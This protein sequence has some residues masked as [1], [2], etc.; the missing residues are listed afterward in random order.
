MGDAPISPWVDFVAGTAGV[1]VRL[2]CP[3]SS[4]GGEYRT[5]W[6]TFGRIVKEEKVTGLYKGVMSPMLGVAAVNASVFGTY[7]LFMRMLSPE[8][9][10]TPTLGQI[11]VAGSGSGVATSIL[12]TPLE[13]LKI[14]Q[15]ISSS[16]PPSLMHLIRTLPTTSLYRG[17]TPTILRDLAYGPY[18]FAYELIV[19][20]EG[21]WKKDLAEE[22]ESVEKKGTSWTRMMVAGGVAGIVGW[23]VTFPVD[24]VKSRMQSSPPN[25]PRSSLP[26]TLEIFKLSYREEGWSVFTRGLGPT[27][28]RAVPVNMD[29][30]R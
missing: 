16:R 26:S 29:G 14:L 20:G 23:G 28:L 7:G 13:R 18:F 8:P 21:G 2:Q 4:K 3:P 17:L 6:Q 11:L 24:V 25:A 1:K 9:S 19:R 27:L 22:V 30:E 12:T 10:Q 5:A 15:Q